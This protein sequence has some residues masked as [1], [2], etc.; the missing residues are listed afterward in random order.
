[1]RIFDYYLQRFVDFLRDFLLG[2]GYFAMYYALAITFI[3]FLIFALSIRHTSPLQRGIRYNRIR[4]LSGSEHL[5]P[6]SLLVPA[7]NEEVTI[8]E[9]VRSLLALNYPEY[10]VIVVNDGPGFYTT[11]VLA[12]YLG[13]A[14]WLLEEGASVDAIDGALVDF[15]FPVGPATLMDEV[16]LDVGAKVGAVLHEAFG[17]RMT[18]SA[19]MQRIVESGRLGRKGRKGFYLYD[20]RGKK[21]E[22]DPSIYEVIGG[23]SRREVPAAEIVQRCVLAMVN[24]AVRC[25]DEG[26]LRSPR[27]GDVGA[28]FGLGFPPFRGG[29]FRYVDAVG[30]ATLVR[31]LESLDLRFPR[32]FAPARG[33]AAMAAEGRRF[34]PATGKPI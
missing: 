12:A 29:P 2:Y 22:V 21:G 1:M 27:D 15:G 24:E 23:A 11:R 13:E 6:V 28:V 14:G 32:R 18:P 3:Y 17:E 25:L 8:K 9:N 19:A 31:Q 30:A 34:Y 10:E 26:I 16:G 20:E 5:P 7:Y 33:L 4:K